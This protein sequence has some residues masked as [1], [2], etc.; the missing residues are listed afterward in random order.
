MKPEIV[1]VLPLA[2]FLSAKDPVAP[3]ASSVTTSGLTTA[4]NAAD[5]VFKV[6]A[7]VPS[8][9]LLLAVTPVIVNGIAVSPRATSLG[10]RLVEN[11]VV[12]V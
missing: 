7:E 5:P 3:V 4:L 2:T 11:A 10:D 9:I 6:A 12:F 1:T 8:Y